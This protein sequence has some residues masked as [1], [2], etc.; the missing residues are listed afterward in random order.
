VSDNGTELILIAIRAGRD[1][2]IARPAVVPGKRMQYLL[3]NFNGP[4]NEHLNEAPFRS[5][6]A[7]SSS[8]PGIGDYNGSRLHLRSVGSFPQELRRLIL[9]FR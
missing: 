5:F 3:E 8:K 1:A 7:C 9:L 2:K 6:S 4:L